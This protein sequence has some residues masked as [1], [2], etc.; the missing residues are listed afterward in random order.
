MKIV[1][2]ILG[3]IVV[4][5]LLV[6]VIALIMGKDY[7]VERE[8]VINKPKQQVFDYIKQL[9]N[10][11]NYSK[12]N[13]Q[14]P[15]MKKDFKGTDGTVG[16][17]YAWDGNDKAGKGEQEIQQ[18]NNG[19][20]ITTELRFIK[21]FV[22]EAHTTMYTDA[23]SENQTKV[24]WSFSSSMPYPMNIMKPFVVKML[25]A[26]QDLSLQNLKAQLEKQ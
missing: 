8:I 2:I 15:N 17:V 25:S 18:I 14:D 12:W 10:Q 6:L 9:K 1:K 23:I 3:I 4:V 5:V 11:D 13:M 22:G 24:R 26:D 21:P 19:E 20:S 7:T 16:F